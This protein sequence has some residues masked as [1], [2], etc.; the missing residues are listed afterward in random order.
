VKNL[1]PVNTEIL[2]KNFCWLSRNYILYSNT[3]LSHL[4]YSLPRLG[5][6]V[7]FT[8]SWGQSQGYGKVIYLSESLRRAEASTSTLW[9]RNVICS[10][11]KSSKT[12]HLFSLL[13]KPHNFSSL[14]FTRHWS[15]M[16]EQI[17][18]KGQSNLAMC[19]ATNLGL[20]P[21]SLLFPWGDRGTCKMQCYLG[22]HEW[23][24]RVTLLNDISFVQRL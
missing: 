6:L 14:C 2:V 24:C 3:F 5:E 12:M 18:K 22:R 11:L 7:R 23:P 1:F 13:A 15:N 19:I 17:Y 8:G 16:L 21:P 10:Y 20:R 4:V 9:H